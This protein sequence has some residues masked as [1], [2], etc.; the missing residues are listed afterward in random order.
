[1]GIY[2]SIDTN[3]STVDATQISNWYTEVQMPKE[4]VG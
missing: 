1:M 3:D 2:I 4:I